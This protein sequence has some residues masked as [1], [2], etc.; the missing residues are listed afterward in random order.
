[1]VAIELFDRRPAAVR[2][3]PAA[4]AE[5]LIASRDRDPREPCSRPSLS[6][7]AAGRPGDSAT[8]PPCRSQHRG[9][10]DSQRLLR[11]LPGAAADTGVRVPCNNYDGL[12]RPV[13]RLLRWLRRPPTNWWTN[14]TERHG[15]HRQREGARRRHLSAV[16]GGRHGQGRSRVAVRHGAGGR[17]RWRAASVR[18]PSWPANWVTDAVFGNPPLVNVDDQVKSMMR[19]DHGRHSDCAAKHSGTMSG[20]T[21]TAEYIDNTHAHGWFVG[22]DGDRALAVFVATRA[23]P[24]W[25]WRRPVAPAHAALDVV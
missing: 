15:N 7:C 8:A 20:K 4:D 24:A 5:G 25:R 18:S 10:P 1:M 2:P 17:W 6:R 14:Y 22:I 12:G 16:R 9:R 13:G 21:G 3:E 11:P 19:D 23:V